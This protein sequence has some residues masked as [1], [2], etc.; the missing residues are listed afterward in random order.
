MQKSFQDELNLKIDAGI[1]VI[2]IIS[3]EWRRVLGLTARAAMRE[4]AKRALFWWNKATAI[5]KWDEIDRSLK[6]FDDKDLP[7]VVLKWFREG[8]PEN[9]ILVMED[10]HM[11]LT[12]QKELLVDEIRECARINPQFKKTLVLASPLPGLPPELEKDVYMLEIPLPD[13]GILKTVIKEVRAEFKEIG[14]DFKCPDEDLDVIA[15]AALGL[16]EIEAKYTFKEI[17][18]EFG[19]LT[20]GEIK[21]VTTQ[22]E[23]IIRKSGTLEYIHPENSM[24]DVGGMEH[25]KAWLEQQKR[26]FEPEATD[27]GIATPKGVL[28]IGIPGCGKS[29]M[30]KAIG[31]AWNYPLLKFDLGRVYGGIVGES[32]HNIRKALEI[33]DAVAP[34]VLWVDEIEK[35]IAGAKSSNELD[36]GVSARVFGTLLTWMQEKKKP[37]FVVATANNIHQLPPEFLRKGRFN[38]IFFVDLPGPKSREEIW[39]IHLK[40]RMKGRF[41]NANLDMKSLVNSSC[42]YSG[43]EIEEA[44]N[45]GML[46]AYNLNREVTTNDLIAALGQIYPLAKTMSKE[47]SDLRKWAEVRVRIASDERPEDLK[48]E[49]GKVPRLKA[50]MMENPFV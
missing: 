42:Y 27:Y 26:A 4:D 23:Q 32:E 41:K 14:R 29:L 38:E 13:R 5:R 48:V 34:C 11:F 6:K 17:G 37:V 2:Q 28:F 49:E 20:R 39:S 19:R 40:K 33:A 8:M 7:A 9:A 25:L 22:K 18:M 10:L 47:L 36:A 1:P 12:I 16:T 43:S 24:S 31:A 15:A 35:G 50:E 30:A 46:A 45:S 21:H 44:V 3:Y